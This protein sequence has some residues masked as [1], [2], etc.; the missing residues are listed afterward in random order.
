M[1]E[2]QADCFW[3]TWPDHG[4]SHILTE[5]NEEKRSFS[6]LHLNIIPPPTKHCL[7]M[8]SQLF[9]G[10]SGLTGQTAFSLLEIAMLIFRT[11]SAFTK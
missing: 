3:L 2:Q 8:T 7:N 5:Y 9:K 10:V 4:L 6:D 11:V 1:L